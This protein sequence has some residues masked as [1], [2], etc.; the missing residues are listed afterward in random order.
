MSTPEVVSNGITFE[1]E[2]F[3]WV[4]GDRLEVRGRWYGLRGHRFVRPVLVVHAVDER[5]RMLAVLDHKPWAAEDGD[6]WIAAFPWEGDP[7]ELTAAELAVA[8]SLAVD[9][10][11]PRVPGKGSTKTAP[12]EGPLHARRG[13]AQTNPEPAEA[14]PPAAPK[15]AKPAAPTAAKPA[16]PKA[17]KPAAPKAAKRAAPPTSA[18]AEESV[19][20]E[21]VAA[22]RAQLASEQ[23][24]VRRLATQLEEAHQGLAAA[25]SAADDHDALVRERDAAIAGRDEARANANLDHDAVV[26]ERDQAVHERAAALYARDE[27][28][29]E[30]AA[31]NFERK[32]AIAERDAAVAERDRAIE[33][34]RAAVRDLEALEKRFAAAE[35]ARAEEV[36]I[37]PSPAGA[38]RVTPGRDPDARERHGLVWVQRVVALIVLL[39]WAIVVYKVLHGIV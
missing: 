2:R 3:E 16:A 36:S 20:P 39:V 15:A 23:A 1:V 29:D 5:R 30:R 21:E 9:L 22:L 17:A 33:A 25:R 31:A 27:A 35:R 18:E 38:V 37:E 8:P 19:T 13:P 26:E 10:P 4:D 14:T 28:L 34:H 11:V 24:W 7:L 12:S 6:E 32:N